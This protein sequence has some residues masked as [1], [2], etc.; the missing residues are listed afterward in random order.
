MSRRLIGLEGSLG[1][2]ITDRELMLSGSVCYFSI[3][4]Y[5]WIADLMD[6]IAT[7]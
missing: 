5:C 4:K 3:I 1:E 7:D 2:G 6:I